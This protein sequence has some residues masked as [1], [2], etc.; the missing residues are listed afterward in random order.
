MTE[1]EIKE[2]IDLEIVVDAN[3]ED[4]V[5]MGWFYFMFETL[6]FPFKAMATI[7]KR[8][9]KTEKHIVEVVEDATDGDRFKCQAYHVNVDYNGVLMKME[10]A[11]LMPIGASEEVV[12]AITVWKYWRSKGYY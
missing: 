9:G 3:G 7:K 11:D 10:V 8:N 6:E 1:A 5:F 2:I 12:K 4:E